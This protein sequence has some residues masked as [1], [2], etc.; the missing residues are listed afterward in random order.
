MRDTTFKSDLAISSPDL[1]DYYELLKPRVMRLV[2]FTA[3]V[4]LFI[5][6]EPVNP[7]IAFISLLAVALGAGASGALNM[8][9]DADID[10]VMGRTVDRPIPSG[11]VPREHALFLGLFLSAFSVS[12]LGIFAN[13]LSAA[14]L[15]FTIFFYVVI[16]S[17]GLKRRTTQNIVI[18]GAA[19][20]FP[21]MI[22][23]MIATH[24]VSFESTM[25][26][27]VVFVWTP[28]HFWALALFRNEDYR[29]AGVPM[30]P[31]VSGEAVT[32][33]QIFVYSVVLFVVVIITSLT[34]IGGPITLALSLILGGLFVL[35]SFSILQKKTTHGYSYKSEKKFFAL[36]ILFLFLF[37]ISL[38]LDYILRDQFDWWNLPLFM[39]IS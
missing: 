34:N 22:G 7:V 1:R 35:Y 11:R 14:F 31:V 37:F 5:A 27:M 15:A 36:S 24:S 32:R 33:R 29:L 13:W 19:G 12:L 30:L 25:L 38:M 3:F 10:A 17:M 18:G 6:S 26:F 23:W 21:P 28:P 39:V 9:I 20:A 16:Y 8:Y 2:V 4:G